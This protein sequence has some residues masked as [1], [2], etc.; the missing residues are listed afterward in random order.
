[1]TH[2]GRR[3]YVRFEPI[4]IRAAARVVHLGRLG[5]LLPGEVTFYA[6]ELACLDAHAGPSAAPVLVRLATRLSALGLTGLAP[7]VVLRRV[8]PSDR[9]SRSTRTR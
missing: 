6:R 4:T 3:R 2:S 1:M 8:Q 7:V 5:C 9:Q